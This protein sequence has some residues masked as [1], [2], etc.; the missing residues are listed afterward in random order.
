MAA[1]VTRIKHFE[2]VPLHVSYIVLTPNFSYI[3]LRIM[4]SYIKYL[5]VNKFS[6]ADVLNFF[7]LYDKIELFSIAL[8]AKTM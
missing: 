8:N 2:T 4:Y 5:Q 1:M 3:I 6:R 7:I